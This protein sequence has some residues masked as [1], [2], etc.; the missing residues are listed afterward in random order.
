MS[1]NKAIFLLLLRL[2]LV[3]MPKIHWE[4]E[5]GKQ[6]SKWGD[7]GLSQGSSKKDVVRSA[8]DCRE[9]VF[10]GERTEFSDGLDMRCKREK[11]NKQLQI[12]PQN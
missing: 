7:G 10:K 4:A 1:L 3:I 8:Q 5:E 2:S 12:G 6:S 9:Q 11:K